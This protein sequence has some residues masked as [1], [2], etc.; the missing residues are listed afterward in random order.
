MYTIVYKISIEIIQSWPGC[1]GMD[2]S[3]TNSCFRVPRTVKEDQ[4]ALVSVARPSGTKN[5]HKWMV[6]IFREWQRTRTIETSGLRSWKRFQR[7][8]F[9]P[10]VF[11][12]GQSVV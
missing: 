7:L 8:R 11:C 2:A 3:T 9:S 5:K 10:R 1:D 12:R 4:S 6:G